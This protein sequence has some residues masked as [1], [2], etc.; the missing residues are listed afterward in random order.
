LR[1]RNLL[2]AVRH[3]EAML[4]T[5]ADKLTGG[6]LFLWP[7]TV[8]RGFFVAATAV[9]CAMASFAAAQEYFLLRGY[10]TAS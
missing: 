9:L 10:N 3:R 4:H 2:T 1:L 6:A 8:G 7:L 5:P